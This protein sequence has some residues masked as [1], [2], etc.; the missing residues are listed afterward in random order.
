[1]GVRMSKKQ[2]L[3]GSLRKY[4]RLPSSVF[5]ICVCLCVLMYTLSPCALLWWWCV[6]DIIPMLMQV[7]MPG[8]LPQGL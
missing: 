3:R 6:C 7:P 5:H 4:E 2:S 1:M 8:W